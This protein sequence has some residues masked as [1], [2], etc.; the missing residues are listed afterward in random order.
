MR[1]KTLLWTIAILFLFNLPVRASLNN[2]RGEWENTDEQTRGISKINISITGE[3]VTTQIWGRCHPTDCNWGISQAKIYGLNVEANLSTSAQA[4]SARFNNRGIDHLVIFKISTDGIL[5][6]EVFTNFAGGDRRSDY[7]STE[8]FR[9]VSENSSINNHK[10]IVPVFISPTDATVLDRFPL[11]TNVSNHNS[12]APVLA[13]PEEGTVFNHYPRKTKLV[14]N[15]VPEAVQ[16]LVEIDFY[17][18]EGWHLEYTGRKYR[19][20]LVSAT[21]FE[22][23][24]VGAQSGRW[25]IA[26]IYENDIMG[27]KSEWRTFRYTR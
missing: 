23:D 10:P 9:R 17:Y 13:S 22:F 2:F 19:C 21:E 5:Q 11:K 16:Y 6:T 24:F 14:W 3:I 4:L 7:T 12:K 26:A 8:T 25:R 18:R 15:P 1:R 20:L 27:E